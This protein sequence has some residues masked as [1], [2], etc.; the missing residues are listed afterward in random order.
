MTEREYADSDSPYAGK[1]VE[2]FTEED[3]CIC[4]HANE[5]HND[6]CS[7]CECKEFDFNEDAGEPDI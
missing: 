3:P 6:N 5:F 7:K 4:G 1:Y 2:Y